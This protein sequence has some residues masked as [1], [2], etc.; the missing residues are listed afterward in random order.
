MALS[1]L[2]VSGDRSRTV[3]IEERPMYSLSASLGFI[4]G[5]I[6]VLS[7]LY[8]TS[9]RYLADVRYAHAVAQTTPQ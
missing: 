3:D 1:A 8:F 4:V 7:G 2:V 6:L 5:L 9:V